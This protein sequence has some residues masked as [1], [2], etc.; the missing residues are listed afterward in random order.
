MHKIVA[1]V[2]LHPVRFGDIDVLAL[3][4]LLA[5]SHLTTVQK[6]WRTYVSEALAD[7]TVFQASQATRSQWKQLVA[8]MMDQE[9][10]RL[11][12]LLSE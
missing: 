8:V 7:G 6:H 10:D 11:L 12:D 9:R 5:M 1:D 2:S 3:D 4:I